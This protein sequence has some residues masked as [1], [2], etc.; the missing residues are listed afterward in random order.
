MTPLELLTQTRTLLQDPARWGKGTGKNIY[1]EL[2]PNCFCVDTALIFL[3]EPFHATITLHTAQQYV[4][5]AIGIPERD[6]D[7]NEGCG[8][9]AWHD[10][11]WRTHA[12]VLA[13]LD[14]AIELAHG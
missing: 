3:D 1:P 10:A 4:R 11:P 7:D 5:K 8:F 6:L 12:E 14:K 13:A 2:P 9:Y